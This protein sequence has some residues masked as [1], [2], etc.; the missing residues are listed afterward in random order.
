MGREQQYQDKS[1]AKPERQ[2]VAEFPEDEILA[3]MNFGRPDVFA[4]DNPDPNYRYCLARPNNVEKREQQGWRVDS[5]KKSRL[6][7]HVVMRTTQKIAEVMKKKHLERT[8]ANVEVV[9][10]RTIG[11]TAFA[12]SG[13]G[14][15]KR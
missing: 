12:R 6:A 5:S 4:I 10:P 2:D 7:G 15:Q 14:T 3:G 1:E 9:D 8:A 13:H 11:P